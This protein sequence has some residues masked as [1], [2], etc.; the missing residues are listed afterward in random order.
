M[1]YYN[2]EIILYD[3]E[4]F[5]RLKGLIE[6]DNYEYATAIH[7]KDINEKTGELIKPH[8]HMQI[9]GKVQKSIK[10]WA[11]YLDKKE[12]EIEIIK[13][14]KQA[15]Q[16]LI[17]YN[18]KNK[19]HY[20]KDIIETNI[21]IDDIFKTKSDETNELKEL[22]EYIN[23]KGI[24]KFKDLLE[25]AIE[26]NIWSTYRRNYTILKDYIFEKNNLTRDNICSSIKID[27]Q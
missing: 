16:Y 15:I 27:G 12:N 25:Y 22:I 23:Q 5:N 9:Y 3:E 7:D 13:F 18:E 2:V 19:Y 14:K 4:E 21:N 20:E 17:H 8:R 26:N 24:I 10:S 1:K 11:K 6:K